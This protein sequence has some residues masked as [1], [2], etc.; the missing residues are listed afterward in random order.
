MLNVVTSAVGKQLGQDQSG[1]RI[2]WFGERG[3]T[4]AYYTFHEAPTCVELCE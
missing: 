2:V 3:I 1:L 4:H